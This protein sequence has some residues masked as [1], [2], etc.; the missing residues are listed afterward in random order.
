MLIGQLHGGVT[1][2]KFKYTKN[3][4]YEKSDKL[5]TKV[6]VNVTPLIHPSTPITSKS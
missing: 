2:L 3:L 5:Y 1:N 6:F 4:P